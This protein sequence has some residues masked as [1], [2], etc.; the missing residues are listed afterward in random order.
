MDSSKVTNA[1]KVCIKPDDEAGLSSKE[2]A[3]KMGLFST[4]TLFLSTEPIPMA[5]RTCLN[6]AM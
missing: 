1:I 5:E 2:K 4:S 3:E 6:D